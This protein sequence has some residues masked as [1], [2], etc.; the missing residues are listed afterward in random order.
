MKNV[1]CRVNCTTKLFI[2][3]RKYI[4]QSVKY[5]KYDEKIIKIK[6]III[7]IIA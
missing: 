3:K 7:Y 5:H 2:K 6:Y 1:I 4:E